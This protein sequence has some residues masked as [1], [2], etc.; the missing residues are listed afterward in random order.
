MPRL[1]VVTGHRP[2][3]LPRPFGPLRRRW[4]AALSAAAPDVLVTGMAAGADLWAAKWAYEHGVPFEAFLPFRPEVQTGRWP[5]ETVDQYTELLAHAAAV[6]IV[7]PGRYRPAA[8]QERNERM[9]QRAL[10]WRAAAPDREAFLLPLWDGTPGGTRNC[11]LY[12]TSLE[13]PRLPRV[14]PTEPA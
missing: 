2:Q 5:E 1:V 11:V 10:T 3:N 14:D 9:V 12:A 4:T 6:T 7:E 13:L 8:L